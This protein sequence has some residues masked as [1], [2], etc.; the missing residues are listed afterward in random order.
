MARGTLEDPKMTRQDT[1]KK[2]GGDG[3]GL[4]RQDDCCQ[5]SCQLEMNCQPMFCMKLEELCLSLSKYEHITYLEQISKLVASD[6]ILRKENWNARVHGKH[7][8][9]LEK[10]GVVTR[11]SFPLPIN[12][13]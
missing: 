13:E 8:S 7:R 10:T 6:Q 5:G 3:H 9:F 11:T 1:L 12:R 4:V 2:S